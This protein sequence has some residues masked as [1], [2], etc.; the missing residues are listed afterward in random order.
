MW[1]RPYAFFCAFLFTLIGTD[2]L[3]SFC[4]WPKHVAQNEA[5]KCTAS[6][7][8]EDLILI[9]HLLSPD[10]VIENGQ[11]LIQEKKITCVGCDCL[12]K[13]ESPTII[14]CPKAAI[15]PGFIN[16][17]DHLTYSNDVPYHFSKPDY[18]AGKR[19]N[20]RHDWRTGKRGYSKINIRKKPARREDL[21]WAEIRALMS[22]TTSSAS[23]G[24]HKGLIRNLDSALGSEGLEAERVFAPTFPLGD[25]RGDLK[26]LDCPY[27]ATAKPESQGARKLRQALKSA[28][29]SPH[30]AEGLDE[31]AR[32][33]F[34]C[35]TKLQ[36]SGVDVIG[37]NTS[38]IHGMGLTS[39]DYR[40]LAQKGASIV[41]SPRSNIS[42][43]GN[44]IPLPLMK[45]LKIPLSLGTDWIQSGSMNVLRELNCAKTLN[46]A[47]FNNPYS[48]RELWEMVTINPSKAF[49]VHEEIGELKE[50]LLADIS[51]FALGGR[52]PYEAAIYAGPGDVLLT[53]RGG[54]F[55]YGDETLLDPADAY[56]DSIT[57][58]GIEKSLCIRDDIGHSLAE[59]KSKL[60]KPY[61]LF[62]CEL[63]D[64]EP[65]CAPFRVSKH[66]NYGGVFTVQDLDGDGLGPIDDNCPLVFNPPKPSTGFVQSDWDGDGQGDVCDECPFG[67]ADGG[68]EQKN[69]DFDG[70]AIA[71]D[72]DNCPLHANPL[73]ADIDGDRIGNICDLCP[74][75]KN[76]PGGGCPVTIPSLKAGRL[77]Y[78]KKISIK[79]GYVSYVS[80]RGFFLQ[81]NSATNRKTSH[82]GIFAHTG[83]NSD[84]PQVGDRVT[85][86]SA[87][88]LNFF[89]QRQLSAPRWSILDSNHTIQP[90]TIS[91]KEA[92][93]AKSAPLLHKSPYEGMLISIIG[94][95]ITKS[96][97]ILNTNLIHLELDDRISVPVP[98]SFFPNLPKKGT[99][100]VSVTGVLAWQYGKLSL[101]TKDREDFFWGP[102]ITKL[103]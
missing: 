65:S 94:A 40:Y 54:K 77:D 91:T 70:D 14:A 69:F 36:D 103:E 44:T 31:H 86:S 51:V 27:A 2:A 42:L 87:R 85:I 1:Q 3:A 46:A 45:Q 37:P 88:V 73:Q 60:S 48:P 39:S 10:G 28:A 26:K 93:G 57:V 7:S 98:A 22:G 47:H 63:P 29:F 79:E 6:G 30:V 25:S 5:Q 75:S 32:N 78:L 66:V 64:A 58:C 34:L 9:G 74:E 13:I 49:A 52:D 96:G 71:D 15:S 50:G 38:L 80:P 16:A 100:I 35:L 83:S 17:H 68:C 33:E 95:S 59:I 97:P 12:D 62:F 92:A 41:W 20:H 61:P 76:P 24:H 23:A 56:C 19:Y 4:D 89:R 90:K 72:E 8:G 43:Y 21:A 101:L 53:M 102:A 81:G 82:D 67:D 18:L 84:K 55:L 99:K 11:I